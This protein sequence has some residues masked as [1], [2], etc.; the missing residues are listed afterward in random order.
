MVGIGI[1]RAVKDECADG[2]DGAKT[3]ECARSRGRAC[4]VFSIFNF[5]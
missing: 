5:D 4:I 1:S 2:P 3:W